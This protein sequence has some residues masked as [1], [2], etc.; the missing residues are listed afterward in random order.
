MNKK[1][2]LLT[3]STLL[4]VTMSGVGCSLFDRD[5]E[6]ND[7]VPRI[8]SPETSTEEDRAAQEFIST[9]FEDLFSKSAE[10][11]SQNFIEGS[12]PNDPNDPNNIGKHIATRTLTEGDGNP[13][14]GIHFPRFIEF[15]GLTMIDYNIVKGDG[16]SP[17]VDSAYIGKSG[18]SFLYYVKVDVKATGMPINAFYKYYEQDEDTILFKQKGEFGEEDIEDNIKGQLIKRKELIDRLVTEGDYSQ[19][20]NLRAEIREIEEELDFDEIKVQLKYDVEVVR[21]NNDYKILT[22]KEVAYKPSFNNRRFVLNNEFVDRLPY[23][24][25]NVQTENNVYQQEQKLIQE[26]FNDLLKLDRE[27]MSLL[28]TEWDVNVDKFERFLETVG[29]NTKSYILE[30]DMYKEKF[31]ILAFPLQAGM[32]RLLEFE[33]LNVIVH[34]GYSKNNKIYFVKIG[35]IG[36]SATGVIASETLKTSG[37][38]EGDNFYRYD[39]VIEL[40]YNDDDNLAVSGIKLEEYLKVN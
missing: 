35:A 33:N 25:E 9:Y 39:Y 11:Y 29:I 2:K 32:T 10:E 19:K 28:R 8:E 40:D 20:N 34:P 21:E 15:G 37:V 1:L 17:M 27:R 23:L 13:E 22:Q 14:V 4:V 5:V 18:E 30:E 3:V 6:E 12:I 7:P 38:I 36:E 16:G 24:D 31:S 26:F